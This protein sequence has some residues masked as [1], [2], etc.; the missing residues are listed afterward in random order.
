[1]IRAWVLCIV[2]ALITWAG[3]DGAASL[4]QT[5]RSRLA[6]SWEGFVEGDFRVFKIEIA[7]HEEASIVAMTAGRVNSVTLLF[8]IARIDVRNDRFELDAKGADGPDNLRIRGKVKRI[9]S[10]SSEGVIDANVLLIDNRSRPINSWHVTLM[11]SG[12]DY[13]HRLCQLSVDGA[14]KIRASM[15]SGTS[16]DH[17]SVR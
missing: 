1:M 11:N 5:S 6:G 12:G 9:G 13:M 3:P 8:K 17:R 10:M 2:V 7:S 15:A 14:A 4:S 16:P